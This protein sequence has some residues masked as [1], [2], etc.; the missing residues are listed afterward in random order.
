M[1]SDKELAKLERIARRKGEPVATVAY[2]I[3]ARAF[4]RTR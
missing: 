2:R 4:E 3:F 1:L